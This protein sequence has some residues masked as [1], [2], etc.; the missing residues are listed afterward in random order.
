MV[1]NVVS[2]LFTTIV[3]AIYD[4]ENFLKNRKNLYKTKVHDKLT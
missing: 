4:K 3:S 2:E 1:N